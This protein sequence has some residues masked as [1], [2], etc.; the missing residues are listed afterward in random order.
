[1]EMMW[2]LSR[3]GDDR[4]SCQYCPRC[5]SPRNGDVPSPCN[6][7]RTTD[8]ATQSGGDEAARGGGGTMTAAAGRVAIPATAI[9]TVTTI[10]VKGSIL[11]LKN[12]LKG[13]PE[14]IC[15]GTK[16]PRVPSPPARPYC[17][18]TQDTSAKGVKH[19]DT[20]KISQETTIAQ[21]LPMNS[22]T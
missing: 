18:A 16:Q 21:V 6:V 3:R 22:K 14:G 13:E 19:K 20:T 8:G 15:M 11:P 1:M 10:Q 12:I 9:A 4:W 2:R 17:T 5:E 7:R